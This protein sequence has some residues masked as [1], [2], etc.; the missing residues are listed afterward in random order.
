VRTKRVVG[1]AAVLAAALLVTPLV[2]QAPATLKS[3]ELGRGRTV[4]LLHG[5][6]G[7][8]MQWMP[9]ARKLMNDHR[10]VMLDLPGHGES[11]M[12]DPFSFEA[13]AAMLDLAL[14]KLKPESTIVVGHGLGGAI[15]LLEAKA[16]PERMKGLIVIDATLKVRAIPDA[17]KKYFIQFIEENYDQFLKMSFAQMGRDSAEGVT[18]HARAALVP[19]GTMK[20]YFRNLL[21]LDASAVPASLKVPMMFVGSSHS[22]P[23][24][25]SWTTIAKFRGFEDA[26]SIPARRIGNSGQQIYA[27]QPDSLA[28]VI[29]EFEAKGARKK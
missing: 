9:T 25:T 18:L 3:M 29:R 17:Q 5:I 4:V 8:R 26:A 13:C 27:D 2:A 28:M 20:T 19:S 22:W 24:T 11:P 7:T 14:A 21:D 1:A 6:G 15:A 10:V 12:P 23:D 16:H